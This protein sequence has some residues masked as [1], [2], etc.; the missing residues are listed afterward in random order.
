MAKKTPALN[1]RIAT[2]LVAAFTTL[3]LSAQQSVQRPSLVVGIVVDGLTMDNI[4]QLKE[5]FSEGGFKRLLKDGV[6]ITDLDYHSYLDPTAASAMIFTGTYPAVNGICSEMVYDP[7]TRRA[8]SI[9]HDKS[10]IGNYTNETFSPTYIRTS[11]IGDE[12]RISTG[13]LGHVYSLAP[14]H[15]QALS[16][17]GHAGNSGFWINKANGKWATTT[18]YK[19]V[20]TVIQGVNYR[21]PLESRLDTM[22]W[23]S[24]ISPEKYPDLPKHRKLF[25]FRHTFYRSETDRF[26]RFVATPLVNREITDLATD[27][28]KQLSLGKS[29]NIDMLNLAFTLSPYPYGKDTDNRMEVMDSYIR[30]DRDLARLFKSIDTSGPGMNRT[31][32]FITGTPAVPVSRKE[33]EKWALATGDFSPRRAISLLNMYLIALHGN[34]EWVIG[35]HDNQFF[36]NQS[37]IKERDINP[38]EIRNEAAEFLT[39]MAGVSAAASVDDVLTSARHAIPVE[40]RN[41]NIDHA[42]DVFISILPGWEIVDDGT[43]NP[44]VTT[45]PLASRIVAPIA[46]GFILAPNLKAQ[47]INTPVDA[48]AIAPTVSSILR[49]RSPNAATLPPIRFENN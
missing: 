5:Y 26:N 42:G 41:I 40:P 1:T 33:D 16:L 47:T 13:G 22:A 30:L 19:D 20:P 37:L 35:Y 6:T 2:L 4:E 39:R 17:A 27:Y 11:T 12:I 3:G 15:G 14:T 36:L 38:K 23:T 21:Y 18:F 48:R 46:P 44:S 10:T 8:I 29:E 24:S 31:L 32:V 34:G 9:F 45:Y 49:I 7:S 43:T 25:S 28:I